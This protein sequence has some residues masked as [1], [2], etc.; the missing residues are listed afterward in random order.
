MSVKLMQ[1]VFD[2]ATL[3]PTERLVMLALADHADDDGRCYPS[4][5]RLRQRTGLSE[6][7]VQINVKKLADQGYLRV[8]SGGGKSRPNTYF[9][10]PNPAPDAPTNPAYG[11]PNP[12]YGAPNPAYG[13]PNPAYGAP[14]PAPDAPEPSRTVKNQEEP[15]L[16]PPK[17]KPRRK[18]ETDLP[19]GW[20]PNERNIADAESKNFTDEEIDHEADRFRNYHH[21]R[22]SRYRDWDAAWRTW[23]GNARKFRADRNMAFSAGPGG[24]GQGGSIA[25]IVARRRAEGK[26]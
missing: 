5:D 15:P 9:I 10:T 2:S 24:Y 3:G 14:N 7:A 12:A 22:Q 19:A 8:V 18:P 13:A 4:I 20:V 1:A 17:P 16:V 6:R 21:S 26:V 25:S 11:A 23:I